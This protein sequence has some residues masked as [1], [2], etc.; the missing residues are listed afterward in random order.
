MSQFLPPAIHPYLPDIIQLFY[1][2]ATGF[3]IVGI[4]K[5]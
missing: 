4:K 5:L 2:L 1:L 3:F